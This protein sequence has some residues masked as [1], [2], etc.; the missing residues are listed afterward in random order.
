MSSKVLVVLYP[1][2]DGS[3]TSSD[4]ESIVQLCIKSLEGADQQTRRSL[5]RLVGHMLASTQVER[6]APPE[7]AKKG[8]KEQDDDNDVPI[9]VAIQTEGPKLILT[10]NQMLQI[11]S[12]HF[13]KAATTRKTRIGIFDFYSTLLLTLG[14]AWVEAN[15]ALIVRHF[16]TEVVTSMRSTSSRFEILT[17]RKLVGVLLRDL[18]A[19]RMLS[20][21]G[22]IGAIRELSLAYIKK[23]PA[24]MPGQY[25]PNQL[26]LV[27]ALREI[28]G[29][30]QQLGSAPPPVQVS[31]TPG[32]ACA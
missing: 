8:K 26:V 4:V 18:I 13:N 10:P 30:L 20:E 21:Q 24:V 31:I 2:D 6:K 5:A 16:F 11:L 25:A 27:I 29:L 7:P 14:P 1:A 17:V 32:Q 3:R 22:Q 28:A 15:Y 12:L 23:W 9:P 19:L